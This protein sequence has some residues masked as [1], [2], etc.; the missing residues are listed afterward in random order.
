MT[1][2]TQIEAGSELDALVAQEVMGLLGD[3]LPSTRYWP[4]IGHVMVHEPRRAP[5]DY[6]TSYEGMGLVLERMQA[7]GYTYDVDATDGV[8]LVTW[9]RPG[10]GPTFRAEGVT[11]PHAVALAA[12]TAVR[13]AQAPTTHHRYDP[14]GVALLDATG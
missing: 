3:G 10:P 14:T 5:F 4:G 12:L 11:L 8:P 7:L 9:H 13:S 6:S 1:T 2:A